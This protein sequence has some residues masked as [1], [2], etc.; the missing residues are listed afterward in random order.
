MKGLSDRAPSARGC[1]TDSLNVSCLGTRLHGAVVSLL[2]TIL[3]TI[4]VG[5]VGSKAVQGIWETL[6]A[7]FVMN[8]MSLNQHPRIGSPRLG[9]SHMPPAGGLAK[10]STGHPPGLPGS[11]ATIHTA[12]PREGSPFNSARASIFGPSPTKGYACLVPTPSSPAVLR[13]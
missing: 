6:P 3:Q 10:R 11:R 9:V 2:E 8:G 5:L 4:L 1:P 13:T 12:P 7:L